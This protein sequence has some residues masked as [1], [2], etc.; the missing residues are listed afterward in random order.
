MLY[1]FVYRNV[2]G[3][4]SDGLGILPVFQAHSVGVPHTTTA[5][6]PLEA[7]KTQKHEALTICK[8]KDQVSLDS[9][10]LNSNIANKLG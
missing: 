9:L 8:T 2:S 1:T 10:R 4:S 3:T 5:E 6:N 7:F